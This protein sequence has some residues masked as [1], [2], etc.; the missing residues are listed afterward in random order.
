MKALKT[1]L[2]GAVI[3]TAAAL[4]LQSADAWGGGPWGGGPWGGGPWGYPGMA[5]PPGVTAIPGWSPQ[6]IAEKYDFYG[7]YGPSITDV[8]RL[9]RDLAW[10]RPLD[11]LYSPLGP[12]P[13]DIRRQERRAFHRSMGLPY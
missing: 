3:A 11:N 9:Y 12:S 5:V 6:E 1:L 10:G 8:R 4:P 7:P 13:T 2:A